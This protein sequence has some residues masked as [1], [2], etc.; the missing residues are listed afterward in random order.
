MAFR[1]VKSVS[2]GGRLLPRAFGA[3]ANRCGRLALVALIPVL[4]AACQ[5]GGTEA[6]EVGSSAPAVA[7]SSIGQGA[8][9]VTLLVSGGASSR[10]SDVVDGARLAMADVGMSSLTLTVKAAGSGSAAATAATLSIQSGAKMIL[11]PMD[12]AS[13]LAVAGAGN[14]TPI[15]AFT[16]A[17]LP[18]GK[19]AWPLYADAA[20]S[21]AEGARM[22]IS[23]K[24]TDIA[25]IHPDGFDPVAVK[26]LERQI[27]AFGGKVV[28]SVAY[29]VSK[30]GVT[31]ALVAK[32]SQLDTARSAIVLGS[33]ESVGY[34]L[35]D[36]AS[37]RVGANL[38]SVAVS[39][40]MPPALY[41]R[42]SA[43]GVIV[44][45]PAPAAFE[46]IADRYRKQF[47]RDATYDS[48]IGY[49]AVA[50]AAGLARV[51]GNG[52]LKLD[53]LTGPTGFRGLTGMF[54][55]TRDGDIERRHRIFRIEDGAPKLLQAEG[56]G[57]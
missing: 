2:Q 10:Q 51:S 24:Q 23:A 45:L 40:A 44:A 14:G 13:A 36:L 12:E 53:L 19:P 11:G 32:K 42:P 6:L 48:A 7:E 15:L 34:V 1:Y 33:G 57:F 18:A 22:V 21:A 27:Q 17:A 37:G 35:D 47:G 3:A 49:D 56:E 54:R 25:L 55:F 16:P 20:D 43:Q 52:P 50:I 38:R 39:S 46:R 8:L 31:A 5:G 26:R 30:G 28:G 29:P 4:L 41:G 9:A